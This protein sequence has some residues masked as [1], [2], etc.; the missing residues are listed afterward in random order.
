MHT[1]THA[2]ART[3][4]HTKTN[5]QTHTQTQTHTHTHTHTHTNTLFICSL[6]MTFESLPLC[7][8][9]FNGSHVPLSPLFRSFYFILFLSLSFSLTF[10]L[11]LARSVSF[12]LP[13]SPSLL[14]LSVFSY[15]LTL[16]L[17]VFLSRFRS[18]SHFLSHTLSLSHTHCAT[19]HLIGSN[20]THTPQ[21]HKHSLFVFGS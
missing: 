12:S 19:V 18:L 17:C 4:T 20:N 5:K 13:L 16:S 2:R 3:H 8:C 10:S 21:T 14:W 1:H 6:I 9:L 15:F 11:S 7:A